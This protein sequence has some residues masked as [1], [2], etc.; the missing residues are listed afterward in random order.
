MKKLHQTISGK[1]QESKLRKQ[2][3][4]TWMEITGKTNLRCLTPKSHKSCYNKEA[5]LRKEG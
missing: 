2:R 4:I 5:R 3:G 1:R